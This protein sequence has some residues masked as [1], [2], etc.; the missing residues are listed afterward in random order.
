MMSAATTAGVIALLLT[1]LAAF[2]A[3]L[4]L[5]SGFHKL[6]RRDRSQSVVREFAGVPRVLA[7]FAAMAVAAAELVAG[8]LLLT[9]AYRAVGGVLAASIWAVYL[10]LIVRAIAQGRRDVDCGCTFGNAHRPLGAF[11]VTRNAMLVSM[12]ALVGVGALM[13][14]GAALGMGAAV[15]VGATVDVGAAVSMGSAA[16]GSVIATEILA[17]LALTALYG[18]LEQVMALRPPRGGVLL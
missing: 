7:P 16:R 11:Q 13:R 6:I 18:A 1:Q 15:G 10:G 9:P 12:G 5:A 8:V 14:V 3:L 2:L 17:A 4:L